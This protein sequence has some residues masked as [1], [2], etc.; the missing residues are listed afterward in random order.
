MLCA[1]EESRMTRETQVDLWA[2][3][4]KQYVWTIEH[5]FPQGENIP[6]SWVQMIADGDANVAE[7]HRQTYAHCLGNLTISGYNS[8][9]GN[10]SF[11][12][13]QSRTDSQGREVGYNNGL[14]LNQALATED[15]WT[16]EKLKA[17]TVQLVLEVLAKYPLVI[18][19]A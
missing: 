8:A 10:K 15:S 6:D 9:L 14:Y 3:K 5:I 2:L 18:T 11:G 19:V 13:K 7:Q 17:R 16:V 12:E 4:G 1:L